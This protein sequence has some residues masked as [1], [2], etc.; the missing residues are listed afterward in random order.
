MVSYYA[1]QFR[2]VLPK[3]NGTKQKYLLHGN[4]P[5][6]RFFFCSLFFLKMPASQVKTLRTECTLISLATA[7][8]TVTSCYSCLSSYYCFKGPPAGCKNIQGAERYRI[9]LYKLK[10]FLLSVGSHLQSSSS[11]RCQHGSVWFQFKLE[12]FINHIWVALQSLNLAAQELVFIVLN[13]IIFHE[14]LLWW[15]CG[16]WL[17][18]RGII[19]RPTKCFVRQQ[20]ES[21][22]TIFMNAGIPPEFMNV[23]FCFLLFVF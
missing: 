1:F 6:H 8:L 10:P 16:T 5:Q 15:L 17:G 13:D 22:M 4:R 7:W 19:Q 14:N 18:T 3:P 20:R 2:K 9:L 21:C 11:K 23:F 12:W